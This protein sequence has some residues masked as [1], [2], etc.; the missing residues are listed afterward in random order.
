MKGDVGPFHPGGLVTAPPSARH[1]LQEG[2]T[3]L[4]RT[5]DGSWTPTHVYRQERIVPMSTTAWP[6]PQATPPRKRR[7]W[8]LVVL[9]LALVWLLLVLVSQGNDEPQPRATPTEQT[10]APRGV[11]PVGEVVTEPNNA[12]L[13]TMEPT[14]AA[15]DFAVTVT[16]CERGLGDMPRAEG[17]ITNPLGRDLTEVKVAV[18][19]R[20][21]NV[22]IERVP[23]YARDVPAGSGM[24][25]SASSFTET[26]PGEL[27]CEAVVEDYS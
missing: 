14:P 26:P 19:F 8:P 27:T 17:T 2:E 23:G 20:S 25:W 5:A 9:G 22:I 7:R 3:I 4:T 13:A 21:G 10:I 15:P 24:I 6:L 1:L 12:E 11:P 18:T 16:A